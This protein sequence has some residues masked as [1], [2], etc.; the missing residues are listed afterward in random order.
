MTGVTVTWVNT[1]ESE[2]IIRSAG[3]IIPC[4]H[5]S[6]YTD[7]SPCYK[8]KQD[9]IVPAQCSV[10]TLGTGDTGQ[11]G[12][13]PELMETATAKRV[14]RLSNVVQVAVGGMHTVCLNIYGK[15]R[16]NAAVLHI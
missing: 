1:G 16:F 9:H 6:S 12:L 11:L 2:P 8:E 15:V 4:S 13:G 10:V 7:E 14:P 5:A 3:S